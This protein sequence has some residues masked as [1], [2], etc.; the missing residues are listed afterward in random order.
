MMD[1]LNNEYL[2]LVLVPI[3]IGILE[4]IKKAE[5]FN[6]KFIP[7][8]SLILGVI[9]GIIFTGFSLKDGIIA[10]LFIG[11]SAVGLYSSTTNVIEGIK[12]K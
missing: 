1:I 2:T 11:L 8:V 9:L 10:G 12:N 5:L 4:V 7:I 6:S 3:L